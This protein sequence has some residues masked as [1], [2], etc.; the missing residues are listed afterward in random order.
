MA[1]TTHWLPN[2][3]DAFLIKDGS[4]TAAELIET[5][6]A[7]DF[8]KMSKTNEIQFIDKFP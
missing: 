5:L 8:N 3:S 7:P 4:F 6:S 1:N 2:L